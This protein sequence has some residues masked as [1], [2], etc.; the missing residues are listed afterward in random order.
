M[1]DFGQY[2]G[3]LL[4]LSKIWKEYKD[5]DQR[6][7]KEKSNLEKIINKKEEYDFN[8]NELKMLNPEKGEF[9][10]LE[11]KRKLLQNSRRITD[12]INQVVENFTRED[13]PGI[14]S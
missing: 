4:A 7:S 11:Q 1:D 9:L 3:E 6:Y 8:L 14:D 2:Q 5:I 10:K 12:T 13:P